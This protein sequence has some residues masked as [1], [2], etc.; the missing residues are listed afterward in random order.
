G[1]REAVAKL[2]SYLHSLPLSKQP[3]GSQERIQA[4]LAA[5][6]MPLEHFKEQY[7]KLLKTLPLAPPYNEDH[8]E[9]GLLNGRLLEWVDMLSVQ[10]SGSDS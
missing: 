7:A 5:T 1:H 2:R 9:Q 8:V 10:P 3:E 6:R 4:V